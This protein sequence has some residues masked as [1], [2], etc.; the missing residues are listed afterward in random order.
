MDVDAIIARAEA[1][2]K[3]ELDA[4]RLAKTMAARAARAGIT[5]KPHELKAAEILEA[6]GV[7]ISCPGD[8]IAESGLLDS[9][10]A[11]VGSHGGHAKTLKAAMRR[12]LRCCGLGHWWRVEYGKG[13][14][15][16]DLFERVAAEHLGGLKMGPIPKE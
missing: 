14:L 2:W 9:W 7:M 1:R 16:R 11:C 10:G 5:L 6:A 8:G 12:C 4:E 13:E 15:L 3:P